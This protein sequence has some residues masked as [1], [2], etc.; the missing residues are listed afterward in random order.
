MSAAP[1]PPRYLA[2]D[3]IYYMYLLKMLNIH[4]EKCTDFSLTSQYEGS[5]R[6]LMQHN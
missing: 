3:A 6:S 2:G 1:L 5:P 4:K